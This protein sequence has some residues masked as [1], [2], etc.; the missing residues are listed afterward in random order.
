[1]CSDVLHQTSTLQLY[2]IRCCYFV[3]LQTT[4]MINNS[5]VINI[6]SS[7]GSEMRVFTVTLQEIFKQN[8]LHTLDRRLLVKQI[9][10]YIPELSIKEIGR[11]VDL[12]CMLFPEKFKKDVSRKTGNDVIKLLTLKRNHNKTI[13]YI[14]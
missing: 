10:N 5:M 12:L 6:G 8:H 4:Q 7:L 3:L 2:T 14:L 11:R 1:M 13:K 9:R